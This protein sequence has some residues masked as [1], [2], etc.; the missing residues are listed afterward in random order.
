MLA[1]AAALLLTFAGAAF[2]AERPAYQSQRANEDWSALADPALRTQP[3]DALKYVPLGGGAYASFGG[4]ARFRYNEYDVDRFG[5][6]PTRG[7][8]DGVLLQRYLLHADIHASDHVRAFFE[9]GHHVAGDSGFPPGPNDI[10]FWDVSLAFVDVSGEIA[11]AETRLRA[12]RQHITLGSSRLVSLR[13]G[14][15]VRQ[16]FDGARAT[17]AAGALTFD[18][19]AAR[20]V[21]T[22]PRDFDD[23]SEDGDGLWGAYG[24]WK[25]SATNLDLYYLGLD[26]EGAAYTQG[27]A[28]ERRHS[29]GARVWG[30]SGAW[31]WNWEAVGQLGEFGGDDIRAWT[32]ASITGY[33]FDA[34]GKPRLFLSANIASGDGDPG[35]GVLETFSPLFPRLPYFEEATFLAPQNF[36][37]LQPGVEI[38][39]VD[40]VKL[41]FD[42][43]F[44]WR[45]SENDAVYS[46]GLNP[47]RATEGVSG[48]FVT[49]APS[50]NLEW[51]IAQNVELTASYTHFFAGEV[52]KNAGGEDSD[53]VMS[54][55]TV[56][57]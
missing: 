41:S 14:P 39:P 1:R 40:A 13:D 31:D 4:S 22:G 18:L 42:W 52:I 32:L 50:V 10:D 38:T 8:K 33:T 3:L 9:L 20:D 15:N 24:V 36:M 35:D 46:R 29:L 54:A 57:F 48:F 19:F 12:G 37:N 28:D 11:G 21:V 5:L 51:A 49:H 56:Q 7:A 30:E 47:L 27:V 6:G 2:G 53:F 55:I 25:G 45:Q 43:N 16:R 17:T 44:Y 26:R 34:P 23:G